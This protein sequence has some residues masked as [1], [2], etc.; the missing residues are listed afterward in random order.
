[1]KGEKRENL[2]VP[3]FMKTCLSPFLSTG[4]KYEGEKARKLACPLFFIIIIIMT[5]WTETE[6][7]VLELDR[8]IFCQLHHAPI[9][10]QDFSAKWT[11]WTENDLRIINPRFKIRNYQLSINNYQKR[12]TAKE[13]IYQN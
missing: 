1:M 7:V 12:R 2:P 13:S 8:F 9:H 4:K 5:I 6:F 3:F 10:S 11:L